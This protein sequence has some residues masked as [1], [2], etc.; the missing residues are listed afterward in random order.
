MKGAG[1]TYPGARFPGHKEI[2]C[3][4][5]DCFENSHFHVHWG[6]GIILDV[7]EEHRVS[8]QRLL[9]IV[10]P[11]VIQTDLASLGA[12]FCRMSEALWFLDNSLLMIC[13]HLVLCHDQTLLAVMKAIHKVMLDN[14][15]AHILRINFLHQPILADGVKRLHLPDDLIR[16]VFFGRLGKDAKQFSRCLV[17]E[18]GLVWSPPENLRVWKPVL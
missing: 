7:G 3:S 11:G 16:G 8:R 10:G 18:K 1:M 9:L 14:H 2:N 6:Q 13:C 17:G 12:H 5:P 4:I 15:L